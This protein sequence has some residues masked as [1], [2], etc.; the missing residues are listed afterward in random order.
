MVVLR[1]KGV[2]SRNL[3]IRASV[4]DTVQQMTILPIQ[5][6]KAAEIEMRKRIMVRITTGVE[7]KKSEE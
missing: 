4:Y 3:L 1:S 6:M 7:R 5:E 2:S